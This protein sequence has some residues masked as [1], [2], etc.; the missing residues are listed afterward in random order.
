MQ[1]GPQ[2]IE[3]W[4]IE[5]WSSRMASAMEAMAG[6]RPAISSSSLGAPP[7]AGPADW[8]WRQPLPPLAGAL[9]ILASSGVAEACGA[10]VM[11]ALGVDNAPAGERKSTFS[12]CLN[13]ASAGLA[14]ALTGRLKHEV[15]SKGGGEAT[16]TLS[17]AAWAAITIPLKDD[18]VVVLIGFDTA[19]IDSIHAMEA[20][21]TQ[22]AMVLPVTVSFGLAHIPLMDSLKLT[23]GSIVE[24][25]RAVSEPVEIMVNNRVVARGEVVVVEGNFGVRIQEVMN[26]QDRL[27]TV[28]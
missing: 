10:H 17:Q 28:Q 1:A 6:E 24:L 20:Q 16:S 12:E 23:T 15:N 3:N 9:W 11:R 25:N 5:E 27:R 7:Q 2:Q 26:R 8:V 21:K 14:Q 13:Q 4:L 18:S 22:P 19:L